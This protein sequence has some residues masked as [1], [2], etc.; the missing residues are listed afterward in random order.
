MAV[1]RV[2]WRLICRFSTWNFL[3][4]VVLIATVVGIT[5][6]VWKTPCTNGREYPTTSRDL[7]PLNSQRKPTTEPFQTTSHEPSKNRVFLDSDS[8]GN[9]SCNCLVNWQIRKRCRTIIWSFSWFWEIFILYPT[10]R[11]CEGGLWSV[12]NHINS[13]LIPHIKTNH[14]NLT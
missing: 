8:G 7:K 1:G 9:R 4:R 5:L 6:F 14:G 2:L 12:Q 11:D 13:C 3:G 10:Q